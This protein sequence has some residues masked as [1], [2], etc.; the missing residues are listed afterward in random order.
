VF[1][2]QSCQSLIRRILKPLPQD[3]LTLNEIKRS[4]WLEG[5]EFPEPIE[6][7]QLNPAVDTKNLTTDEKEA[8]KT[9]RNLGINEE[10]FRKAHG[11]DSRSSITG[12]YR[13]VLHKIQ[14]KSLN[15]MDSFE[16]DADSM[17]GN[18]ENNVTH[19]NKRE[20]R[21]CVIL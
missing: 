4:D 1:V 3:R 19:V 17:L 2:S 10:H 16:M 6:A 15:Q 12:T 7:F 8:H 11:K 20:S 21:L 13:I 14:K 9:L 5:E 18:K